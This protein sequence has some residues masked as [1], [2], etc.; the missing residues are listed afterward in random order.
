M[1]PTGNNAD[2]NELLRLASRRIMSDEQIQLIVAEEKRAWQIG[3][4]LLQELNFTKLEIYAEQERRGLHFHYI[5]RRK[6]SRCART[7]IRV[8][9]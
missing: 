4:G 8:P 7:G 9:V 2:Y 5:N 3:L 1:S 6:H